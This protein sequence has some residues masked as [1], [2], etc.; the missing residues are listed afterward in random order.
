MG[1]ATVVSQPTERNIITV[2]CLKLIK[3]VGAS[4][5]A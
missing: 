4:D 5:K 3:A 1:E 2:A